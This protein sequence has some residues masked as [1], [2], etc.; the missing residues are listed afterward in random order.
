MYQ[1]T[2]HVNWICR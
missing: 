2:F 1:P